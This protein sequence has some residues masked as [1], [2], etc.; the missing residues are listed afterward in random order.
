[1]E[2]MHPPPE[3]CR[4]GD[5]SNSIVLRVG[6]QQ[7]GILLTGDLEG[8]GLDELLA[9]S[10]TPNDVLMA[11]HHGSRLSRP[12]DVTVWASPTEVIISAG[13]ASDGNRFLSDYAESGAR[14]WWTHR[15]GLI[16]VRSDPRGWQ[17]QAWR[18][19]TPAGT[20]YSVRDPW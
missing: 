19:Q 10:T 12:R 5:N 16:E 17:V 11:P 3:G 8:D 7:R 20:R 13:A 4:S 14:V 1:M 18:E 6:Y 9:E 15:D 2:I